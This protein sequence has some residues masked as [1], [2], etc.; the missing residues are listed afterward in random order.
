M[1]C[2]VCVWHELHIERWLLCCANC[3]AGV[4]EGCRCCPAVLYKKRAGLVELLARCST[5]R[6]RA[7]EPSALPCCALALMPLDPAFVQKTTYSRHTGGGG[8]FGTMPQY[9]GQPDMRP[10]PAY[11]GGIMFG[12]T[13][14]NWTPIAVV[15]AMTLPNFGASNA[16]TK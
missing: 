7:R 6:A 16:D 9:K 8:V 5:R 13:G 12:G 2:L 1:F 11:C 4:R 14:S 10:K 15:P 3:V